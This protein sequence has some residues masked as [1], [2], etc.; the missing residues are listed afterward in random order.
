M[1]ALGGALTVDAALREARARGV[2]RLD[3][4]LLLGAVLGRP[5]AW[6]IAHDDHHLAAAQAERFRADLARRADGVPLAYLLG[7]KEFHGLRLAV[8][9]DVLVPRPDTETLVD[10][11]LDVLAELDALRADTDAEVPVAPLRVADLGTGSGAIALAIA[12]AC[13]RAGRAVAVCG[14]DRS[15]TALAVARGNGER[16]GFDVEWIE[17]DWWEA[18]AGRRFD[19]LVGNPPYVATGDPHLGALR[20]EPIATLVA[21]DEGLD[22]LRALIAGATDHLRPGGWLLLEHGRDQAEAVRKLLH[23][24]GL[25]AIVMRVDLAGAARCSGGQFLAAAPAG[26]AFVV[27]PRGAPTGQ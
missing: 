16:L 27:T 13:A 6:L 12:D 24:G 5:R 19:L 1:T 7:E 21:G 18:L 14:V 9:P 23:A 4:H 20:H 17:S 25:A 3:A 15:T 8:T 26:V 2:D 10:W 11:A 22:D